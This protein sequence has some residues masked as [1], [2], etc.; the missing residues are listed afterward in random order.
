[1]S[2]EP[3]PPL[4]SIHSESVFESGLGRMSLNYWKTQ[5]TFDILQSLSPGQREALRVKFD[6][7]ILNGNTRIRVLRERNVD[8]D[9]L[10]REEMP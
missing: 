3:T 1:M 6:G 2:R 5:T 8:V 7:R 4:I 9:S 10:P